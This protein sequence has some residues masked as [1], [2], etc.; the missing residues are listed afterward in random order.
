M[1]DPR[2]SPR[3]KQARRSQRLVNTADSKPA[4]GQDKYPKHSRRQA[5]PVLKEAQRGWWTDPDRASPDSRSSANNKPFKKFKNSE[6]QDQVMT[7]PSRAI[8]RLPEELVV[9]ICLH[10]VAFDRRGPLAFCWISRQWRII[11]MG[12]TRLWIRP[13]FDVTRAFSPAHPGAKLDLEAPAR[14]ADHML[15]WVERAQTS[16]AVC[17]SILRGRQTYGWNESFNLPDL[18]SRFARCFVFLELDVTQQQLASLFE[19]HSHFPHLQSLSLRLPFLTHGLGFDLNSA[20]RLHTVKLSVAD[21]S[22][23]LLSSYT[24]EIRTL[25]P[26]IQL[27]TVEVDGVMR[28]RSN[29]ISTPPPYPTLR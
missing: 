11:A 4:L 3:F 29:G 20:P 12:L 9:E 6:T 14:L 28:E 15:N 13:A 5:G 2:R 23:G 1:A 16:D 19:A 17:L 22:Y 27:T 26:W 25:L 8:H 10:F 21:K 7:P 24:G 18:V